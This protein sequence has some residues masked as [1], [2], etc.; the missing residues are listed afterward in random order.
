MNP[1]VFFAQHPMIFNGLITLASFLI[2][3]KSADML[4]YGID[5]YAERLGISDYL[6]GLLVVSITASVPEFVSAINGL[7]AGDT[8]IIFGTILG[9]NLTG[10]TLVA[11]V[12]A[13]VGRKIKL[14]NKVLK[15]ME[16]AMFF[17]IM[18]PF[19]LGADGGLSRFDAGILIAV[20]G[21]YVV[22]AWIKEKET[23]HMRRNV[24]VKFLWKDGLI[25]LLALA[26]LFLSSRFLVNSSIVMAG[27][28]NVPTYIMAILV[29]GIASSLPDMLVGIRAILGGDVG[30]GLGSALGSLTVKSLLFL[31]VFALIKPLPVDFNLIGISI[32]GT[33]F[34]LAI[35]MYL[36]EKG[37][38]NWKNGLVLLFIYIAYIA[39]ELVRSFA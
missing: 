5:R 3:V 24:K 12:F 14:Q 30:V 35:I 13:L 2:M 31:G 8:G 38:M 21:A 33:V 19:V 32:L 4:V 1:A 34:A 26:A 9:S 20:Y 10:I 18:L 7:F 39:V 36:S 17:M 15:N 29:L 27:I 37:E 6:I 22:R 25:F 11:G 23:G 16:V 28:L